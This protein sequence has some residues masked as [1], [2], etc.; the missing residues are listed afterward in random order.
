MLE[1]RYPSQFAKPEVQLS[2][3]NNFTQNNLSLSI[4]L[5]EAKAIE[6]AA[7]PVRSR[8]K[9]MFKTYKPLLGNGEPNGNGQQKSQSE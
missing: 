9:E 2:L 1:R 3:T 6:A 5:G 8:V 7:E 4:N